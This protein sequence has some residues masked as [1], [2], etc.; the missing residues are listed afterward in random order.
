MGSHARGIAI[1]N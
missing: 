1:K